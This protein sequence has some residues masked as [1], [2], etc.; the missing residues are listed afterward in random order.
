M[1]ADGDLKMLLE[2]CKQYD[3]KVDIRHC[4]NDDDYS[5][6]KLLSTK[7]EFNEN[8]YLLEDMFQPVFLYNVNHK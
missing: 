3:D 5:N 1:E 6:R 2:L 7:T 4:V 8:G